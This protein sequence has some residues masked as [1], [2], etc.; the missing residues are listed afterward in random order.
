MTLTLLLRCNDLNETRQFY[1]SRL[2][3]EVHDSAGGTL[4]VIRQG[5]QL[6][7]TTAD[8][9][10]GQ[11][12]C[13]GTIYFTVEDA[14]DYFQSVRSKAEIAWPIQNM[15]YGIREFGIVDCNGYH[16]AFQQK[17]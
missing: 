13:T 7:F 15:S 14:D 8:L 11:P 3:F 4:T 1:E 9:W 16:I 5:G 17:Q 12:R 2:G 6:I 10:D